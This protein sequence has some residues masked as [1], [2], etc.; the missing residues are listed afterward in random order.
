MEIWD[1]PVLKHWFDKPK[2]TEKDSLAESQDKFR[3]VFRPVGDSHE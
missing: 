1:V 2:F 3:G